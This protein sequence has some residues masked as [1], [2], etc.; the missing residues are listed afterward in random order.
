VTAPWWTPRRIRH[1]QE[2]SGAVGRQ[3]GEP[4]IVSM[5]S[6]GP[7]HIEHPYFIRDRL[8]SDGAQVTRPSI[9]PY[10]EPVETFIYL[11]EGRIRLSMPVIVK[12]RPEADQTFAMAAVK[13]CYCMNV[14]VD[15]GPNLPEGLEKYGEAV[16]ADISLMGRTDFA[17]YITT[18]SNMC[19]SDR[20]LFVRTAPA[21]SYDWVDQATSW[22][23]SGIYIDEDLAGE[24]PVEVATSLLDRELRK[25]GI[26]N[27]ISIVAGGSTIRGSD[28]I[29]KLV[30]LGADAV[31]MSTAVELA[32]G[33]HDSRPEG[34][35]IRERVENLLLGIQRELKLLSGAAGVSNL[36]NSLVGNR[37]LLRAV[38]LEREV[39]QKLGVKQAGV[40]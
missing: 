28:D 3:P 12:I 5:G 20:P 34:E 14:L 22:G 11:C 39:R 35:V 40:G 1:L 31:V 19:R 18:W 16:I 17:A 36:F 21:L 24:A 6:T 27:R 23:V 30:A 33:L 29:H 4:P 25:K 37:E 32:V 9:D 7:P 15:V 26:R 2:L 38:E 8:V 10:R 13:A